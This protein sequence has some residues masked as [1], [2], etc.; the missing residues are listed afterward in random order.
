MAGRAATVVEEDITEIADPLRPWGLMLEALDSLGEN[1]VYICSGSSNPY[2]LFGELMSTAAMQRGA[3]GAVCNG[4]VR[5][6]HQIVAL[7]FPVFCRGS[8][9]LDQQGRGSVSNYGLSIQVGGVTV[10]PGDMI[11][12][13]IDGVLVVPRE[14]EVEV[15]SRALEKARSESVVRKALLSGMKSSDAFARYGVL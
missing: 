2:A 13:D 15:V 6:T 8:Y 14:A 12:G 1:D 3:V 4:P 10:R 9:G 11:I 5:D 7:G